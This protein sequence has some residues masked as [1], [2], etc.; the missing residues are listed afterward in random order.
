MIK[1]VGI[2]MVQISRIKQSLQI[3]GFKESVFTLDEIKN[4]HEEQETYYAT[5]FAGKE[6]VYKA[7]N[8][9]IDMRKIEILNRN[10]GA[11]YVVGVDKAHVSITTE[12]DFATAFCILED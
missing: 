9:D 7:L 4:C 1:G 3:P 6:A 5:R 12:G 8:H 2:D 11:P 10:D